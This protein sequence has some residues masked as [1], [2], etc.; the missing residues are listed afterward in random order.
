MSQLKNNE[1]ENLKNYLIERTNDGTRVHHNIICDYCDAKSFEGDRFKCTICYDYDL[2]SGCFLS[3]Q[4]NDTHSLSHPMLCISNPILDADERDRFQTFSRIE[5][6]IM[7]FSDT[8]H[9]GVTCILCKSELKGVRIKCDSCY[10]FEM[11]YRCWEGRKHNSH[12]LILF[13]RCILEQISFENLIISNEL[14]AGSFG[15][16]FKAQLKPKMDTVACKTIETSKNQKAKITQSDSLYSLKREMEAH[17]EIRSAFICKFLGYSIDLSSFGRVFIVMEYMQNGSLKN[18]IK[19]EKT[20]EISLPYLTKIR[21]IGDIACALKD[22]HRKNYIHA[23]LKP[24]NILVT[25]DF[26]AKITDFGIAKNKNVDDDSNN[27]NIASLRYMPPE[28]YTRKY[29]KSVDL[30]SFGLV[31]YEFFTGDCHEIETKSK[32]LVLNKF[33]LIKIS[34]IRDIISSCTSNE[35]SE[36]KTAD[37]YVNFLRNWHNVFLKI[38]DGSDY[39]DEYDLIS[40]EQKNEFFMIFNDNAVEIGEWKELVKSILEES[41]VKRDEIHTRELDELITQLALGEAED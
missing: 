26:V 25:H 24:D 19:Q 30:Y 32:K 18:I 10:D 27:N 29:D 7:T 2:C 40:I 6:L 16:V 33:D 1:I 34:Q 41:G 14:G 12:P 38:I 13:T 22:I 31:V 17:I 5:N 4:Y 20:S 3:S 21:M 23:D 35:P 8:E 15:K 37:Y 11:C 36:R 9:D 28:F 39:K